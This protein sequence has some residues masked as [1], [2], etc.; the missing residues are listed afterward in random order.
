MIN[1]S[2]D[3]VYK[4]NYEKTERGWIG[5]V[6]AGQRSSSKKRK[7]QP[8]NYTWIELLKWAK[9]QSNYIELH[10]N[11]KNSGYNRWFRPSCDRI[12]DNKPYT[13]DN[14][15][16]TTWQINS[17]KKKRS[18]IQY[19]NDGYFIKRW[20]SATI[21]A[22]TLN[23][24]RSSIGDCCAGRIKTSARYIWQYES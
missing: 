23:I 13:L 8:P 14:L 15:T 7:H 9:E 2:S 4:Y 18:I 11:W 20:E 3:P 10:N 1:K 21:A 24:S 19:T 12:S 5:R 6:I 16:L 17:D 22:Y